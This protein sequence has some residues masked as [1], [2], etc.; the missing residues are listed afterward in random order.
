MSFELRN[1]PQREFQ[2]QSELMMNFR[3][4]SSTSSERNQFDKEIDI[5]AI[6]G[7]RSWDCIESAMALETIEFSEKIA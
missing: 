3:S 6:L 7:I 2:L 5:L 1:S 4:D